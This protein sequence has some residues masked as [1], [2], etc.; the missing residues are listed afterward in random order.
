MWGWG[1]KIRMR[2]GIGIGECEDKVMRGVVLCVPFNKPVGVF[3]QV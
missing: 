2:I 1:V 3:Y